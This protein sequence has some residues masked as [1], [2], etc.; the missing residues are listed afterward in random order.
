MKIVEMLSAATKKRLEALSSYEIMDTPPEP[1][2]DDVARR[3]SEIC[4]TPMS[5]VTLL[6]ERRQWFK[7]KV[8]FEQSETPIDQ[9]FCARAIKSPDELLVVPDAAVDE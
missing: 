1:I 3:A 5:A 8:G 7:A 2:Y 9:A 4:G 6:D